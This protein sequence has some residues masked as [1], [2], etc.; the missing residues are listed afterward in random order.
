M[1][2]RRKGG[3]NDILIAVTDGLKGVPEALAAVFAA[4]TLQTCLMHLQ[5]N[6]LACQLAAAFK[7]IYTAVNAKTAV[8]TLDTFESDPWG[9]R[10]P[11]WQRSGAGL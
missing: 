9:Q 5:R 7:Q 10:F 2:S 4:T 3:V 6:S 8:V 1:I 11:R